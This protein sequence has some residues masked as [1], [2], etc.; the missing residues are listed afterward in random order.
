VRIADLFFRMDKVELAVTG[1]RRMREALAAAG[2]PPPRIRQ[3]TFFTISFKRPELKDKEITPKKRIGENLAQGSEKSSEKICNA[4]KKNP[5]IS[6]R[7]LS[8]MLGISSRAVEK[9]L[10]QLKKEGILKRI[11]PAKGGYWEIMNV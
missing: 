6:A 2:L 5:K 8:I 7:E 4:I 10:P 11:G 3:T 1:I 9:H